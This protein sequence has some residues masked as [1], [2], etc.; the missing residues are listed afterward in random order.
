MPAGA[1]WRRRSSRLLGVVDAFVVT[2]AVAGAF[3]IRFG[4]DPDFEAAGQ[5]STYAWLSLALAIAWWF[6]LGAWNSRQSGILGAG[7]DE[8]KRLDAAS[9]WLFGIVAIVSYVLRI[10]TAR[11]YVGVALPVGLFGLL[12]GRWLIRQHLNIN[13]QRGD[14]M[15]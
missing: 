1:D 13:R 11:G 10:D 3:I 2:W 14:S 4:L 12:M 8:Y 5:E 6:M 7:P 15:S 9:L